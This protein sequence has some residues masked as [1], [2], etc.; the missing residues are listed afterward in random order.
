MYQIM[1]QVSTYDAMGRPSRDVL[2]NE[3]YASNAPPPPL[4]P[5]KTLC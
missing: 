1:V 5:T 2:S 4:P 3:V